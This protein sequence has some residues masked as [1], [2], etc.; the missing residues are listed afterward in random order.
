VESIQGFVHLRCRVRL[1]QMLGVIGERAH[2][3]GCSR[4][5]SECWKYCSEEKKVFVDRVAMTEENRE[6]LLAWHLNRS[7]LRP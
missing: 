7:I 4:S 3:E 1:N 6:R 2:C 5:D